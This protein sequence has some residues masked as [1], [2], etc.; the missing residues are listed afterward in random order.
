ETL[1]QGASETPST[2]TLDLL[3]VTVSRNLTF[4][5]HN[6]KNV[7]DVRKRIGVIRQLCTTVSRG[8]MLTEI[9]RAIVIGNIQTSDWETK[10]ARFSPVAETPHAPT[11]AKANS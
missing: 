7:Q 3:E 8:P 11:M 2:A 5:S 1:R 9:S 10:I 4:G 6:E